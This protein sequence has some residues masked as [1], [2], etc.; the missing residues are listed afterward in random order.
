MNMTEAKTVL[1]DSESTL[2][3]KYLAVVA[4]TQSEEASVRDLVDCLEVG[5]ICAEMAATRLHVLTGR[6]RSND[7]DLGLY[8]RPQDWAEYVN[9]E[10]RGRP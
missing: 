4:I 6:E 7:K 10:F 2:S 8:L 5:G 9:H 1:S 3:Q